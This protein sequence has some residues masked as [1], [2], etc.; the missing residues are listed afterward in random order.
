MGYGR[1]K[2]GFPSISP[3]VQNL[4]LYDRYRR[5]KRCATFDPTNAKRSMI[6]EF[7]KKRST[8]V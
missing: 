7:V 6:S 8:M 5:L 4:Q 2:Y 3:V 1:F